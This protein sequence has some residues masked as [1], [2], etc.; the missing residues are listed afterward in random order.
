ML[1]DWEIYQ[2]DVKLAFL[3]GLLEKEI[4]M[5]QPEGFITPG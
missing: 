1:E 2:M 3:N 4:Y 5:K